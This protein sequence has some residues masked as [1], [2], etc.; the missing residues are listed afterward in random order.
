MKETEDAAII[1]LAQYAGEL[2]SQ[3]AQLT[4]ELAYAYHKQAV[5]EDTIRELR[6]RLPVLEAAAGYERKQVRV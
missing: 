1:V 4:A 3:V 2:E 5:L 6:K